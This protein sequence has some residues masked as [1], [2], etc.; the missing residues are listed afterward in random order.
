MLPKMLNDKSSSEILHFHPFRPMEISVQLRSTEH[1]YV[2]RK[3]RIP[4]LY[5]RIVRIPTLSTD[6]GI[7]LDNS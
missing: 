4:E 7:V 2:Q 3:V 6:F 5:L 1:V